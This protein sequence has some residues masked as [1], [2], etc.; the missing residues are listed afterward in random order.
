MN[1][2]SSINAQTLAAASCG[3]SSATIAVIEQNSYI[4]IITLN[5]LS[6]GS[7][8]ALITSE[9]VGKETG[10]AGL[11]R[12]WKMSV[13]QSLILEGKKQEWHPSST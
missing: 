13:S 4:C 9:G 6:V 12:P 2:K 7:V 10:S 3:T 11:Y 1:R 5:H 8:S